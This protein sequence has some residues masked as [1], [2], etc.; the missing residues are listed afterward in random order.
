MKEILT[1]VVIFAVLGTAMGLILAVAS[2][3]LS[4]KR[5]ERIDAV[6]ECL[7]GANCGG[8]G[9]AGCAA[10]AEAIVRG[11]ATPNACPATDPTKIGE[12][13]G[14]DA[15]PNVRKVAEVLCSGSAG[16]AK[17]RFVY[18]NV[19]D[20]YAAEALAG[21]DKYCAAGCIGL[22]S[23]VEKCA[24]GA[25]SLVNG[26]AVVDREKCQSCGVCVDICPKKIIRMI[27]YDSHYCV[28]C[29]S[30]EKG[31]DVRL[32]CDAGCIG[33]HL[34]EKACEHGAISLSPA[35]ILPPL[36]T[37][38]ASAAV[39]AWTNVPA[40]SSVSIP[41]NAKKSN[42]RPSE[43]DSRVFFLFR[44]VPLNNRCL[45]KPAV[46]RSAEEPT[47]HREELRLRHRLLRAEQLIRHPGFIDLHLQA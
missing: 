32:V 11:E 18:E 43:K 38:S 10:L 26:V 6:L 19:T 22:G 8:C 39:P 5:D 16:C 13:I 44:S 21:G 31:K 45:I 46:Q 20:C 36:T 34:C 17:H 1:P 7:P 4:L 2:K 15:Q 37:K 24:F 42:T 25:L 28:K 41:R 29:V 23:C 35:A 3:L 9:Y 27:P 14:V 12:I 30:P 40:R 47:H 33:C